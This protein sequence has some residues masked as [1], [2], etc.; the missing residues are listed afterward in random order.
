[1]N[2]VIAKEK[3]KV[4]E[5]KNLYMREMGSKNELEKIV[6]GLVED[7]RETVVEVERDK[8]NPRKRNSDLSGEAREQLLGNLLSNEKILTLIYDKTFYSGA[9]RMLQD[10]EVPS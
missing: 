4:R 5:L 3:S 1:M 8:N 10:I 7:V 2:N 6:R 9:N